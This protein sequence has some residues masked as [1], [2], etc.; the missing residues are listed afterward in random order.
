MRSFRSSMKSS[1]VLHVC[2][3][4]FAFVSPIISDGLIVVVA[5]TWFTPDRR[6]E[7]AIADRK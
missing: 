3:I 6:F 5:V 2:A 4:G 7:R 1:L